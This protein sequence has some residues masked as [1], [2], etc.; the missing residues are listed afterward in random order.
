MGGPC[1]CMVYHNGGIYW[2]FCTG[3]N[4]L[5]ISRCRITPSTFHCRCMTFRI[6]WEIHPYMYMIVRTPVR[7]LSH[8]NSS[9]TSESAS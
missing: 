1:Y 8:S 9:P 6:G 3:Q 2:T 4:L 5:F 7:S